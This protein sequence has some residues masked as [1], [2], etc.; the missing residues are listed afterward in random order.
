MWKYS[1]T[2]P[3]PNDGVTR[4]KLSYKSGDRLLFFFLIWVCHFDGITRCCL[5]PG[6]FKDVFCFFFTPDHWWNDPFFQ[7]FS[8]TTQVKEALCTALGVDP[9]SWES[10][11]EI[12]GGCSF[13]LPFRELTYPIKN[14]FWRWFSFLKR[15]DMLN[16]LEGRWISVNKNETWKQSFSVPFVKSKSLT[17][18]IGRWMSCSPG[19]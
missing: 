14:H 11:D 13:N 3:S 6:G 2:L 10:E 8:R 16:S 7:G 19:K 1:W 12:F 15:W 17:W 4:K 9:E 18:R 5:G